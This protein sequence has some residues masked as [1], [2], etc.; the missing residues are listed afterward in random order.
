[1][2][3]HADPPPLAE[4]AT[5]RATS[6]REWLAPLTGILFVALL[7]AFWVVSPVPPVAS[8]VPIEEVVQFYADNDDEVIIGSI[9]QSL[10][11]ATF[12]LFAAVL[13]TRMRAAGAHASAIGLIAGATVFTAAAAVDALINA[14]GAQA[15]GK[16]DPVAVQALAALYEFDYLLVGTAGIVFLVSWGAAIIRHGVFPRWMGWI[17]VIGALPA[18]SPLYIV[19]LGVVAVAVLAASVK[20]TVDARRAIG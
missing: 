12:L 3:T 13:F 16:A 10:A 6:G 8:E 17:L 19:T 4:P 18:L 20:L 5:N 9:L 1:M 11:G 2:T 7:L 14:A 15:A